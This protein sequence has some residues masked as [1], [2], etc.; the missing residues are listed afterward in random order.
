[1]ALNG[2]EIISTESALFKERKKMLYNGTMSV[3]LIFG[4]TGDLHELPRINLL[5]V[6][7]FI[8][9]KQLLNFSEYLEESIKD[10]IP[11]KKSK[12]KLLKVF[13]KRKIKKYMSSKYDKNPSIIVDIIY[14]EE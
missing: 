5:A 12:E 8:E 13:L 1:M 14:Y 11:Y 7:S 3:T 4:Q 9:D 2:D 6:L 10:Y